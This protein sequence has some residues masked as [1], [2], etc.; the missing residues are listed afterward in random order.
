M[1]GFNIDKRT[2]YI[3]IGDIGSNIINEL[4]NIWDI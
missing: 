1:F 2:L 3:I 4:W